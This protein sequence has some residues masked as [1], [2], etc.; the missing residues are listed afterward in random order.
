M[1]N[2]QR[3]YLSGLA[4]KENR[5]IQIGKNPLTQEA[6]ASLDEPLAPRELIQL[7]V[8]IIWLERVRD[9]A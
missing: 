5:I 6:V 7:S 8:L 3:A 2:K 1:N 9:V 4:A